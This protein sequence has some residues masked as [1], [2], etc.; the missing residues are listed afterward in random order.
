MPGTFERS[1]FGISSFITMRPPCM[2]G[3]EEGGEMNRCVPQA[4]DGTVGEDGDASSA[5]SWRP[6]VGE[7]GG[8]GRG[9]RMMTPWDSSLEACFSK[10]LYRREAKEEDRGIFSSGCGSQR[11]GLWW[12]GSA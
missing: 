4:D 1:R 6:A 2:A 10:D 11:R 3:E 5:I 7:V 12:G 8:G 9:R